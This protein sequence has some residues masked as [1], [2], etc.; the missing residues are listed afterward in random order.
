MTR[1]VAVSLS[2]V[3]AGALLAA[4]AAR[5]ARERLEDLALDFRIIPLDR[6]AAPPFALES[7]EGA[8][9]AL[10]DFRGRPVILYFWDST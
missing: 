5:A 3:L 1:A 4:P 9:V 8:R 7:L 10:A 2:L 6:E